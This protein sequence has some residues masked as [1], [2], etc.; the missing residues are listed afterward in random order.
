MIEKCPRC[1]A[2]LEDGK[3]D[4]WDCKACKYALPEKHRKAFA[5]LERVPDFLRKSAGKRR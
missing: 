2:T 5:K 3:W 4:G 1:Q